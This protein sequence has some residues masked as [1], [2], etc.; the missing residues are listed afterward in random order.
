MRDARKRK[1]IRMWGLCLPSGFWLLVP[2]LTFL[3]VSRLL[4][5]QRPSSC[6]VFG[7]R[8]LP[9]S[10]V[11]SLFFFFSLS[12]SLRSPISISLFF[13][14]FFRSGL[15]FLVFGSNSVLCWWL[16]GWFSVSVFVFS[17][18]SRFS[19]V[20]YF[21]FQFFCCV[22]NFCSMFHIADSSRLLP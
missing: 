12:L 3:L 22:S 15:V 1:L 4:Q 5:L 2:H 14:I 6:F 19:A 9:V 17:L 10:S 13:F 8:V 20:Q 18:F 21:C 7:I 16:V 11:L